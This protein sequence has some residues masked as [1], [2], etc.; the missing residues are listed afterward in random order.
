VFASAI[1]PSGSSKAPGTGMTS[2]RSFGTPASV[3]VSRAPSRCRVVMSPLKRLT[4]TPIPRCAPFAVPVTTPTP[5]GM[6][7]CPDACSTSA[8]RVLEANVLVVQLMAELF[9]L[10]LQIPAVLGVGRDLDRHL[11]DDGEPEALDPRHLLRI[12][13]QDANG[14]QAEVGQDLAPDPVF[15]QVG[16]EAELEVGLDGIEPRFLQFVGLQLVQEPDPPPLLRH[17]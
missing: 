17:V 13:R 4:T 8:I 2:I 12:V 7:S 3:S 1:A 6:R 5:C 9:A 10:R 15:A 11:L 16:C 14:G